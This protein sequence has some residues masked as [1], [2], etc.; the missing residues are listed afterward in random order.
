[1]QIHQAAQFA[2]TFK[3]QLLDCFE[4]KKHTSQSQ[5]QSLPI[6]STTGDEWA[7]VGV[8]VAAEKSAPPAART[9]S[10]VPSVDFLPDPKALPK[11]GTLLLKPPYHLFVYYS[12]NN[13]VEIQ[14]S[15]TPTLDVL[16][17]YLKKW[18]KTNPNLTNKVCSTSLFTTQETI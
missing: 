18:V 12:G 14:C 10:A 7:D 8:E 6:H 9:Q 13:K 11:P 1:M 16:H 17:E 15:H 4:E 3:D 5:S 2:S